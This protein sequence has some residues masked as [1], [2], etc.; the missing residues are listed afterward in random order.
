MAPVTVMQDRPIC[1]QCLGEIKT[2][3]EMVFEAPCGH[4]ECA[5]AVLHPLCLMLWR[6]RRQEITE[7]LAQIRKRWL[8]DHSGN[9]IER[10]PE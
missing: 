2:N 5:S 1:F 8:E 3:A 6:E 9:E 10:E 4:R 7:Q